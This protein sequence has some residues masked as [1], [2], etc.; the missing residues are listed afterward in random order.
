ML[1]IFGSAKKAIAKVANSAKKLVNSAVK[2]VS[3]AVKSVGKAVTSAAKGI[4]SG[5]S[6]TLRNISSGVKVLVPWVKRKIVDF[7]QKV[8]SAVGFLY[9]NL[10]GKF[11]EGF[12]ELWDGFWGKLRGIIDID[13]DA[14]NPLK[15]AG[16]G[17]ADWAFSLY[18]RYLPENVRDIA[19]QTVMFGFE[20][21][22][23]QKITYTVPEAPQQYAGYTPTYDLASRDVGFDIA[24]QIITFEYGGKEYMIETW[25]G[26]YWG[27]AGCEVGIYSR[28]PGENK[29]DPY[30][31]NCATDE[32]LPI[33]MTLK[34]AGTDEVLFT[35][36]E[37]HWWLTGFKPCEYYKPEELEME[38]SI[39]FDNKDMSGAFNDA[40]SH[41]DTATSVK[42]VGNTVYWKWEGGEKTD[43]IEDT[44]SE[45]IGKEVTD[46][47]YDE[48]ME[49]TLDELTNKLLK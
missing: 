34:K 8:T 24:A 38:M 48:L 16:K 4:A 45:Y 7:A 19:S 18:Y 44:I 12:C 40:L 14:V 3:N 6:K 1:A 17:L 47:V 27:A 26:D 31:Y 36:S 33:S 13:P 15:Q 21:D 25:K 46:E 41:C 20:Y 2:K 30:F 29:R 37:T 43:K 35:R 32:Q 5:A 9:R 28:K 10:W 11:A 39:T 42:R 23:E 49:G 22:E